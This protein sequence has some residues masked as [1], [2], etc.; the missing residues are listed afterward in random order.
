MSICITILR[1]VAIY[2]YIPI[3]IALSLSL[4]TYIYIYIYI[5]IYIY[6]YIYMYC[7]HYMRSP[8]DYAQL[9]RGESALTALLRR[10]VIVGLR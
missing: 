7:L 9:E 5:H 2:E 3:S 1:C 10:I 6:I 8:E 4:Y